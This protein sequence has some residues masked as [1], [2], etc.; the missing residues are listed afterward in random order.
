MLP[1]L[2]PHLIRMIIVMTENVDG[3]GPRTCRPFSDLVYNKLLRRFCGILN[4][5][6]ISPQLLVGTEFCL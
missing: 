2:Q 1:N 5:I 3:A 4:S 6:K